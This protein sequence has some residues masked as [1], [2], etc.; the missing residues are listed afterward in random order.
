[1]AEITYLPEYLKTS[2]IIS[3]WCCDRSQNLDY[4]HFHLLF[5]SLNLHKGCNKKVTIMDKIKNTLQLH[6]NGFHINMWLA[7]LLK[8]TCSSWICGIFFTGSESSVELQITEVFE[9][10]EELNQELGTRFVQSLWV[11]L[12]RMIMEVKVENSW[13]QTGT[14]IDLARSLRSFQSKD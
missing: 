8:N 4:F 7:D 6:H 14:P 5:S 9:A 3:V 13:T 10:L 1:M 2:P 12:L 11:C